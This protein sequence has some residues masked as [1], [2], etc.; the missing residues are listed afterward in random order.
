MSTTSTGHQKLCI[1]IK[2]KVISSQHGRNVIE[3]STLFAAQRTQLWAQIFPKQLG[4]TQTH[5][6]DH[7]RGI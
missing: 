7:Y 3:L 6:A 4:G 2:Y 1:N 5:A